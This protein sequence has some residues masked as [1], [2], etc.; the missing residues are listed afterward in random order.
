MY[1]P[2]ARRWLSVDPAGFKGGDENLYRYVGNHP[3]NATD[4]SG[5]YETDIHFYMTYYLA[6]AVGLGGIKTTLPDHRGKAQSAAFAI[7]WFAQQV[8]DHPLSNP[9]A[10]PNVLDS[11]WADRKLA[12]TRKTKR[13]FSPQSTDL[14][15]VRRGSPLCFRF[16]TSDT[17]SR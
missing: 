15:G 7:A 11:T 1:T 16:R 9:T 14:S 17:K 13:R 8:D 5:L 10:V 3:T 12:L 6:N 2:E 4:A